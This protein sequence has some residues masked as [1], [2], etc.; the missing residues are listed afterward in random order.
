MNK[1]EAEEKLRELLKERKGKTIGKTVI[2]A[3]L[4]LFTNPADTVDK[5]F[6]GIKD[7]LSDA[8]H[9]LE[10]D[11]MLELICNIDESISRLKDKF[12]SE[13]KNQPSIIFGGSVDVETINTDN[14]VGVHIKPGSEM[15]EFKSGTN[16]KVK[17]ERGKTATGLKI[18][19]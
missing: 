3:A 14:T 11:L 1:N 12:N 18:G 19:E 8:K 4:S 13:Y 9:K 7:E 2:S 17:S 6:F 10:Q 15:V 16:I 5:L